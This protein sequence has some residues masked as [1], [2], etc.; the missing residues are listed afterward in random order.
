MGYGSHHGGDRTEVVL[1][2]VWG[3]QKHDHV[4]SGGMD[5]AGAAVVLQSCCVASPVD[6]QRDQFCTSSLGSVAVSLPAQVPGGHKAPCVS[7][8]PQPGVAAVQR[9]KLP[10]ISCG[11]RSAAE[12]CSSAAPRC[13]ALPQRRQQQQQ[14]PCAAQGPMWT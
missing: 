2:R 8:L 1:V 7:A 11:G 3:P 12:T 5:W 6:E 10:L 9:T 14:L 13:R 4:V